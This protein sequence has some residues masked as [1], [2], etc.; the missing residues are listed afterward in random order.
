MSLFSTSYVVKPKIE[1][2]IDIEELT[3][4][5][6]NFYA[7]TKFPVGMLDLQGNLIIEIGWQTMCTKFHRKH[8]EMLDN[9]RIS[10]ET[11]QGSINQK[12]Y[13]IQKC[14]NGLVDIAIPIKLEGSHLANLFFGQFYWEGEKPSEETIRQTAQKYNFDEQAYLEAFRKVPAYSRNEIEKVVHFYQSLVNMITKMGS[15]NLQLKQSGDYLTEIYN[16]TAAAIFIFDVEGDGI[17]R[18]RGLNPAHEKA[19]GMKSIDVEGKTIDELSHIIPKEAITDIKKRYQRCVDAGKQIEYEEMIPMLGEDHWWL[20]TLTPLKDTSG[21]IVRIMGS[22]IEISELKNTQQLLEDHKTNLE[23]LVEEK[24]SKLIAQNNEL[25]KEIEEKAAIEEELRAS[26]EEL[27]QEIE[28]RATIEEELKASNELLEEEIVERKRTQ[29]LNEK[30]IFDLGERVKEMRCINMINE[31]IEDDRLTIQQILEKTAQV[32]PKSFR[33]PTKTFCRINF[34]DQVF[35]SNPFRET[36]IKEHELL[37]NNELPV[38]FMEVF[39]DMETSGFDS[40]FLEEETNLIENIAS[41]LS[42]AITKIF[43]IHELEE[44]EEKFHKFF[45][46]IPYPLCHID[47]S[48]KFI[49]ANKSF[50]KNLGYTLDDVPDID[51]WWKKACPDPDYRMWAIENWSRAIDKSIETGESIEPKVYEV[52]VKPEKPK[53]LLLAVLSSEKKFWLHF[54]MYRNEKN[55]RRNCL[56]QKGLMMSPSTAFPVFFT[57]ITVMANW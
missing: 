57:C 38:G 49:E 46:E 22:A 9:C 30:L 4:L 54:L 36:G 45:N 20:T 29:Q 39:L 25:Q 11:F 21:K 48:G 53:N 26:N 23:K 33:L 35:E 51:A 3:Q 47:E 1:D 10:D 31:F 28:E 43:A 50:T 24:Q 41:I 34:N 56:R 2:L 44:N 52:T 14:K 12:N 42:Q 7:A 5:F 55:M 18:F 16:S 8:P 15:A 19:S 13:H 32:I 27:Q 40:V 6:S 37:Y 17:F